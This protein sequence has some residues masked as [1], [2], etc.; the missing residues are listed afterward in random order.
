MTSTLPPLIQAFTGA[1]GSASSNVLTYPLDIA[2]TRAQL[3]SHSNK[4]PGKTLDVSK[5]LSVIIRNAKIH[6]LRSLYTGLVP[7]T[8]AGVLSK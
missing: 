4:K 5:S 3:Y 2:T 6:G 8:I 7:D 1:L